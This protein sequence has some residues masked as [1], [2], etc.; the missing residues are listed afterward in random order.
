MMQNF[1][2]TVAVIAALAT[3]GFVVA[4]AQT[5][6]GNQTQQAPSA[7]PDPGRPATVEHLI[8]DTGV[9]DASLREFHADWPFD[10]NDPHQLYD[11]SSAVVSGEVTGIERSFVD[12]NGMIVTSYTV[13]IGQVYKGQSIP[14]VISLTLPGG[15]V[16][17]AEY[18]SSL[19]KLGL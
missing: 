8:I 14:E 15:T 5:E 9:G 3:M 2:R 16:P 13:K 10:V 7:A 17:L 11:F 18:I 12:G 6:T 19:D 1:T 4:C